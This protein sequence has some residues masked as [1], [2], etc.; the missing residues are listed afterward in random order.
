MTRN[1][2]HISTLVCT[3]IAALVMHDSAI[4]QSPQ[5]DARSGTDVDA[6]SLSDVA[7]FHEQRGFCTAQRETGV[8]ARCFE[9]LAGDLLSALST[10][11]RQ[12]TLVPQSPP[13]N[14]TQK[15]ASPDTPSDQPT[16]YSPQWTSVYRAF[17]AIDAS[18]RTGV[19]YVQYGPLLQAAATELA[20]ASKDA[21]DANSKAAFAQYEV[22]MD[23]YRDAGIWWDADIS[24][25]SKR[26]N[27]SI[28][29]RGLP[30]LQIG[31]EAIALKWNVE[32]LEERGMFGTTNKVVPRTIALNAMWTAARQAYGSA[33]TLLTEPAMS[34][35]S[36][37]SFLNQQMGSH[38]PVL[39]TC[40]SNRD[41]PTGQSCRSRKG[42]GTECRPPT[43]ALD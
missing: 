21:K 20:L 26:S 12:T 36:I 11:K 23:A 38:R 39:M 43:N 25:F 5:V 31:L 40:E 17:T 4:G 8:R 9:K 30:Y 3:A 42:G 16:R 13:A 15:A 32:I 34:Q 7:K 27:A 22:A 2:A 24:F 37:D 1:S 10:S 18:I 41:C 28:Y 19:S 6:A 14:S 35:S 29:T 33:H